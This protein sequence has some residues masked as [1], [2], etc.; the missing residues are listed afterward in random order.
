MTEIRMFGAVKP[1]DKPILAWLYGIAAL[2]L[3][4][5]FISLGS[6]IGGLVIWGVSWFCLPMSCSFSCLPSIPFLLIY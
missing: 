2:G 1:I 4:S 5:L 3:V 6:Y